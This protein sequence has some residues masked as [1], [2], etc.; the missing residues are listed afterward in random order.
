MHDSR[1]INVSPLVTPENCFDQGPGSSTRA[2]PSPR[3]DSPKHIDGPYD[4]G[5]ARSSTVDLLF[6]STVAPDSESLP[7]NPRRTGATTTRSAR[8]DPTYGADAPLYP[9]IITNA[10]PW[11]TRLRLRRPQ[12]PKSFGA[13]FDIAPILPRAPRRGA[14]FR[15]ETSSAT[16]GTNSGMSRRTRGTDTC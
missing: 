2:G 3:V 12:A 14:P 13:Q 11:P 9:G 6:P 16:C 4:E 8:T 10:L 7:H 1:A 15:C 5:R